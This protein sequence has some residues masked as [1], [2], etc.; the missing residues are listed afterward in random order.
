MF[1]LHSF[2]FNKSLY[3][4]WIFTCQKGPS[5][6]VRFPMHPCSKPSA[7]PRWAEVP[8]P[9]GKKMLSW[10]QRLKA[11]FTKTLAEWVDSLVLRLH[12]WVFFFMGWRVGTCWHFAWCTKL[13]N[14]P[15]NAHPPYGTDVTKAPLDEKCPKNLHVLCPAR[16]NPQKTPKK[17]PSTKTPLT[18]QKCCNQMPGGNGRQ[19]PQDFK[20]FRSQKRGFR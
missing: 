10:P 8:N 3:K 17:H 1:R 7:S 12:G 2:F 19:G 13:P 4:T 15:G 20:I 18:H 6:L 5:G 14:Q 11:F 16:I 9:K